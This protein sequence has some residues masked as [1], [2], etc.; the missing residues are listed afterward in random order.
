MHYPVPTVSLLIKRVQALEDEVDALRTSHATKADV[1]LLKDGVDAP[2]T[3]LSKAVRRYE[4]K[5]EYLR[6][7]SEE[8]FAL[9]S[10]RQ[11]E[12]LHEISVNAHVI[13]QLRA[14]Q[15]KS[16]SVIKA[17]KTIF[18]GSRDG[19]HQVYGWY[20]KGPFFYLFLPVRIT[21]NKR[22]RGEDT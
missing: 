13:E 5:E 8:K 14:D 19:E 22:H 9:L 10:E 16:G 6:L 1:K 4:R 3:Q 18:S 11:E 2:L 20:E 21:I 12:M 7:S 17:L 15:E